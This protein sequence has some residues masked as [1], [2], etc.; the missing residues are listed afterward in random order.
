[1]DERTRPHAT[2]PAPEPATMPAA[3]P[4]PARS[5]PPLPFDDEGERPIDFALTAAGQRAVAPAS[6]PGLTLVPA[7]WPT[8]RG[9]E[10]TSA[11]SEGDDPGDT[12]PA[13]ARALARAGLDVSEIAS[14]LGVDDL[15][16]GAWT[17]MQPG[18]QASG[19]PRPAGAGPSDTSEDVGFELARA[20]ARR[21]AGRR[22]REDVEFAAGAG[23]LAAVTGV[24]GG[25][26]TVTL[27]DPEVAER[28]VDFLR[29]EAS[30]SLATT[31]V[32]LRIGSAL[33]GDLE[34]HRWAARLG[35]PAGAIRIARWRGAPR[36]DAVEVM[37]RLIDPSLAASLAGWRDAVLMPVPGPA[38]VAF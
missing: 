16:V 10:R 31:R 12:R 20:A 3:A 33:A 21:E 4:R 23:M 13:R 17:G 5:Q 14:R 36:P 2:T 9:E 29:A 19:S 6:L 24:V 18:W 11:P 35:L 27:P 8:T 34:R 37:L 1:M 25:V 30:S 28:V 22:L 7:P 38:D 26:T 15:L 32:V